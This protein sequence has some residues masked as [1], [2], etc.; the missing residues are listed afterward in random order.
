MCAKH[1]KMVPRDVQRLVWANYRPGQEIDKKPSE[2]YLSAAIKAISSV[3]IKVSPGQLS[4][5]LDEE[6]ECQG[7]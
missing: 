2:A 4:L 3:R 5:S 7:E 1:W 6:S